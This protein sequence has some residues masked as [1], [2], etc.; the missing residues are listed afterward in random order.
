MTNS[1]DAAP[2]GRANAGGPEPK[3]G[4]APGDARPE[5]GEKGPAVVDDQAGLTEAEKLDEAVEELSR[6]KR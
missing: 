3:D 6:E 2:A 5:F 1:R 4:Q